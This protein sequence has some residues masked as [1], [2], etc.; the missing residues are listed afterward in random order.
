MAAQKRSSDRSFQQVLS[1]AT[2][3]SSATS[4][5]KHKRQIAVVTFQKWQQKYDSEHHTLSWLKCDTDKTDKSHV[6]LLWCSVCR[7]YRDNICSMK[8]YSNVWVSGSDNHR[9]SNVLDH[10]TSE[11]HKNAM[12]RLRTAQAKARN[13][14]V[15]QYAPIARSLSMLSEVDRTRMRRKFDIS[16]V[17]A[18]EGIAFEK[19]LP[20]CELESRHD[21]ELGHA[22]KTAPSAKLFTYYIAQAQRQ[23]FVKVLCEN[24]FYSFLMDGS[25]DVGNIEQELVVVL[26]SFKDDAAEEFR[27]QTR[28]FNLQA[29]ERADAS[30][31]VKCLSKSL[32]PLGI[33][34]ILSDEIVNTEGRPVLVGGGTDGASVNIANHNGMKGMMLN[35]HPWLVW[36]WCY[37]H[38]LELACKNALNSKLFKD[39]DEML[40]R[41]FYLYEKSPKKTRELE[42]IVKE[43]RE[44]YEFPQGGNRP[45]RSQG[46]RWIN[47]K[48]KA[49]QRVVDRY[50]AYISHL[51]ALSEDSS[52]KADEKARIRGYLRTWTRYSSIVGC[53]MY[54]DILK[55]PSLLSMSL[56]GSKLDVVL[57]IKNTLKSLTELKNLEKKDPFEWPSVKLLLR[58]M[59]NEGEKKLFQGAEL[60]NFNDSVQLKLKQ[61]AQHD[62][63][64]LNAKMKER[65]MW[66]DV[67]LLRALLVFLETQSWVKQLHNTSRTMVT[68][69]SEDDNLS[70]NDDDQVLS[71]V[72]ESVDYLASHFRIPLEAKGV[73]IA[74]LQDEVEDAVEY[75]RRYLDICRT[76]YQKVWYKLHSCPDMGKWP[77]ILKLCALAFSLPFSNGRVEQIFSSMKFVKN[78]RRV[79]LENDTLNDL[80]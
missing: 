6:S 16:F 59:E 67:K 17:M 41:L 42:D 68:S 9:T 47:H 77:N 11:Q 30:G 54:V 33:T 50:G 40:L 10:A 55:P 12:G 60:Q 63:T 3:S 14:P 36:S 75:A 24:S 19:F 79:N 46:S 13:E 2:F 69:D 5:K 76:E 57:G 51:I 61:D 23:Q 29:P 52:V 71:E 44:V 73:V 74:S 64:E 27:S 65:L 58:K 26:T 35:S 56:Q 20:L 37:A 53:A 18:R 49:L 38:R 70:D 66:S 4:T 7:E 34:D 22:Y 31:L 28:F 72:K 62:L 39:V 32:A 1:A 25:T 78:S 8:N 45:V 43:L 48:R 80:H 15:V 21:V